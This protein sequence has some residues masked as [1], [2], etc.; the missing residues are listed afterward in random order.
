MSIVRVTV[1]VE[2]D[3]EDQTPEDVRK[4]LID[5]MSYMLNNEFG[6]FS[7]KSEIIEGE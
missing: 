3:Y 6:P 7:I 4:D 1:E 5:S 2:S